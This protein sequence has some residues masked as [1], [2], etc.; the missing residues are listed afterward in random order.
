M[1]INPISELYSLLSFSKG[2]FGAASWFARFGG[3]G[4]TV[5]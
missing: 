2:R 4:T 5:D 3:F 1:I